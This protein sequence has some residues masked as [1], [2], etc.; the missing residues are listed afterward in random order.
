M[1]DLLFNYFLLLFQI[2]HGCEDSLLVKINL[3][4][5]RLYMLNSL[6]RNLSALH[7]SMIVAPTRFWDLRFEFDGSE[8]LCKDG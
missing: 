7:F 8:S 4:P 1:A 5:N 6:C 2:M 3:V